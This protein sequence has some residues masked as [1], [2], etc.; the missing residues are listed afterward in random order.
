MGAARAVLEISMK[1]REVVELEAQ[2]ADLEAKVNALEGK[3]AAG[4]K[5][6]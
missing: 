4:G 2:M 5:S 1:L 3:D 6:W